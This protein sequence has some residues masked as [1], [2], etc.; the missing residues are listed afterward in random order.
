M[1]CSEQTDALKTFIDVAESKAR[2]WVK[3]R[4]QSG[5]EEDVKTQEKKYTEAELE[6]MSKKRWLNC[7]AR[8]PCRTWC[9]RG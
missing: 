5:E 2:Y 4:T 1:I 7:W 3:G 9:R 8:M 6:Q